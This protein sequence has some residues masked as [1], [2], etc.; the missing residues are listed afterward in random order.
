MFSPNF[1]LT[2]EIT[3]SLMDIEASRQL[4]QS[5]PINVS[6]LASLRESARLTSTHYS[7][8][9]EGNNLTQEQVEE[10]VKGASFP[11]RQRDETEVKNYYKALDYLD[12][13][14]NQPVSS[15]NEDYIKTIHGLVI[16][17][18]KKTSPYRD[19][20]NVIR[21]SLDGKIVYMPPE[22]KDVPELMQGLANWINKELEQR[23]LPVPVIAGIAHYQFATIHPYYD[24]NGR[25]ARLLTNLVLHISGYGL[26]G[27]YSLEE[28]YA[29][30]LHSYYNA[31]AVGES[32]NYYL[33]RAE[34]D[35]TDW[36]CYFC[37]GMALAFANVQAKTSQLAQ[38]EVKYQSHLLRELDQKQKQVLMLFKNS[39]FITTKEIADQ[40][41][42]TRRTA[43]NNC[44]K[45]VDEGFLVEIGVAKK[46]RK[47]ELASKWLGLIL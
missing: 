10:V 6:V 23:L 27:I 37:R 22:A 17:G 3:N 28:Y 9:I 42:I 33:G 39:R 12:D 24:G 15:I 2:S 5:L 20:Q 36:I 7:T 35:I 41:G 11:G 4:F 8:Q 32:H 34:A 43:L 19:G 47:Y 31:L 21:N 18:R 40:L 44:H 38:D 25:T 1:S 14:I 30:D 13:L 29:K 26:K 46:S 16:S 45:W